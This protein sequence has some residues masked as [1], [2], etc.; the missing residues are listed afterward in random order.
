[1]FLGGH[2]F[3]LLFQCYTNV[4]NAYQQK[5]AFLTIIFIKFYACQKTDH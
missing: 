3:A 4:R 1:L 2:N 5:Q